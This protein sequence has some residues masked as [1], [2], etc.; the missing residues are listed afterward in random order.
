MVKKLD[1]V[2]FYYW[3]KSPDFEGINLEARE[4]R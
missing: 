1:L 2:T 4:D 3:W